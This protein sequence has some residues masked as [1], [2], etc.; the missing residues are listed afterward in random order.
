MRRVDHKERPD[1]VRDLAEGVPVD[2]P[3]VRGIAGDDHPW[4]VFFCQTVDLVDVDRLGVLVET[5]GDDVEQPAGEVHLRSVREVAALIEPHTEDR[6]AGVEKGQVGG[7]IRL[8]AGVRLHVGVL[9]AEQRLGTFHGQRL[10]LVD[11]R[12]A[13]VIAPAGVA[14]RVFVR[15]HRTGRLHRR[16]RCEVL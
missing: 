14:L 6:V 13:L 4:T 3:G 12:T 5:V 11:H 2:E 15:E 1:V 8:G 10:D 16:Y 7:H 9:G